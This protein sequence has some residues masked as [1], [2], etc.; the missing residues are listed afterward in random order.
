MMIG[1]DI[2]AWSPSVRCGSSLRLCPFQS[3]RAAGRSLSS[4]IIIDPVRNWLMRRYRPLCT[5]VPIDSPPVFRNACS[6]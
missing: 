4:N 2:I 6:Q 1:V 5:G 3:I